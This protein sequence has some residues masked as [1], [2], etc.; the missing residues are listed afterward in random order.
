MAKNLT[1]FQPGAFTA[2]T[3]LTSQ[4]HR[5]SGSWGQDRAGC[6]DGNGDYGHPMHFLERDDTPCTES[7]NR[8]VMRRTTDRSYG[9]EVFVIT[10]S[11]A[12]GGSCCCMQS[13]PG[14]GGIT[15]KF[16]PRWSQNCADSDSMQ[17]CI[18]MSS[19]CCHA[20]C[21]GCCSSH[22]T[23]CVSGGTGPVNGSHPITGSTNNA[24]IENQF[25]LATL[26]GCGAATV[27]FYFYQPCCNYGAV[28]SGGAYMHPCCCIWDT[29]RATCYTTDGRQQPGADCD[30]GFDCC[31]CV[32]RIGGNFESGSCVN[33]ENSG[34]CGLAMHS[35][36]SIAK[37]QLFRQGVVSVHSH[38]ICEMQMGGWHHKCNQGC[39]YG[40]QPN[41]TGYWVSGMGTS[42]GHSCGGP[43][44]CGA[45]A[46][47][48]M[49]RIIYDDGNPLP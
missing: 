19:G 13:T 1:T 44:C 5:Y 3:S 25:C 30:R 16:S 20:N 40:N 38:T 15:Y 24:N 21:V 9:T 12:S 6:G 18:P 39:L 43:C 42:G 41:D 14:I 45:P 22:Y 28:S 23:F 49:V 2:T 48:G 32:Y 31:S 29:G 36:S 37:T 17:M 11:G 7:N 26:A 10:S 33:R 35:G 27:C 47:G 34:N 4:E 8:H 46:Q